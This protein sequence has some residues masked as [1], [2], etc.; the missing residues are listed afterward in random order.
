MIKTCEKQN[1]F[2]GVNKE[3]N[4]YILLDHDELEWKNKNVD[5]F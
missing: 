2:L 3:L 1:L 5:Y 4:W